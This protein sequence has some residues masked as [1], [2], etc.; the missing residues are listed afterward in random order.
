MRLTSA[1]NAVGLVFAL[2]GF[3]YATLL[4]R[5]PDVRGGLDLDNGSLGLLLLAIAAGR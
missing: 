4:A 5:V 3:L 1:R 2:N